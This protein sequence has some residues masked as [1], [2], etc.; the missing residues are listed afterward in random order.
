M[1]KTTYLVHIELERGTT[2]DYLRL[3]TLMEGSGFSKIIEGDR[4]FYT[5]PLGV[6]KAT[7]END[8]DHVLNVAKNNAA[9]VRSRYKAIVTDY[10]HAR[11]VGLSN[12]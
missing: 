10:V 11:W 1:A 6:Y 2:A 5:L 4:G 9:R 3:R 12:A 8:A 7:S